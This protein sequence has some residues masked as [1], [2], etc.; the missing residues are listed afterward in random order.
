MPEKTSGRGRGGRRT[1]RIYQKGAARCPGDCGWFGRTVRCRCGYRSLPPP[2]WNRNGRIAT[3]TTASVLP[4]PARLVPSRQTKST[5]TARSPTLSTTTTATMVAGNLPPPQPP[6]RVPS[7]CLRF[8][9]I[10]RSEFA[11][12]LVLCSVQLNSTHSRLAL[13]EFSIAGFLFSSPFLSETPT[14]SN[15]QCR[16]WAWFDFGRLYGKVLDRAARETRRH[17]PSVERHEKEHAIRTEHAIRKRD[18]QLIRQ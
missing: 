9:R 14:N 16:W 7:C 1:R 18:P 4:V 10:G 2:P 5:P 17:R 11:V 8:V 15:A 3:T 6:R 12:G 13:V